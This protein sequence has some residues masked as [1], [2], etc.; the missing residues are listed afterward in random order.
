MSG[1]MMSSVISDSGC[2][3]SDHERLL[4]S[5]RMQH[6]ESFRLELQPDQLGGLTSSSTTRAVR[7]HPVER[8]NSHCPSLGG[9][10]SSGER[11]RAATP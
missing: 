10:S 8:R 6:R 1:S 9:V 3:S 4:G 2:C 11:V 5:G 7:T